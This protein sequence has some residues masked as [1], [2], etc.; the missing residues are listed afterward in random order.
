MI[1][2][3]DVTQYRRWAIAWRGDRCRKEKVTETVQRVQ[4]Y[5]LGIPIYIHITLISTTQR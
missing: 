4:W 2:R 3:R 5:L 1:F